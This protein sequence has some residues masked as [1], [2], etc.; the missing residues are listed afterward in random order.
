M[1]KNKSE[2]VFTSQSHNYLFRVIN[3]L[4]QK[5]QVDLVSY[6]MKGGLFVIFLGLCGITKVF[7]TSN[8]LHTEKLD[9]KFTVLDSNPC[10]I[11]V[12]GT[13]S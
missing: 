3:Y 2:Q 1:E 12:L 8:S 6:V 4:F 11:L 9:M 10:T 13:I 7:A 5:S